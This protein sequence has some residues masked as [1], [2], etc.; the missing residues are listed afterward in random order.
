MRRARR[1]LARRHIVL[2]RPGASVEACCDGVERS[3]GRI[4]WQVPLIH[5]LICSLPGPAA[6]AAVTGHPDVEFV[7]PDNR[8]PLPR[9]AVQPAGE[10]R[11]G[12]WEEMVPW[13][14][15]RVGAPRAWTRTRGEG[16]RVAV[17]D[18]GV[19]WE[20]PDLAG[21]VRGGWNLLDPARPPDDD[22]GHGTHVA[23]I[24][25]AR[26]GDGGV[27]GVAPRCDLYALKAFDR[28]GYGATS[29]VLLAL[30]WCVQYGMHVV[31]TTCSEDKRAPRPR[32]GLR[33]AGLTRGGPPSGARAG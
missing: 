10:T 12:T 19:D 1:P 20:H 9:A 27:V 13:G 5:G 14:V 31:K 17:V 24:I 6:L 28:Y 2:T 29:D 30:Q 21:N 33:R 23:G 32:A 26:D 15:A 18:T 25:G 4:L 11:E 16:V 8:V 22:N 3:G 7:E